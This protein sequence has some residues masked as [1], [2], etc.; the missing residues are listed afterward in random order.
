M[1]V[2]GKKR[3]KKTRK[4]RLI[5]SVT[6]A[7]HVSFSCPTPS[8]LPPTLP[9]S[10]PPSLPRA[11]SRHLPSDRSYLSCLLQRTAH[12]LK[13]PKEKRARSLDILPERN[14]RRTIC[15]CTLSCIT[16]VLFTFSARS[17]IV[18]IILVMLLFALEQLVCIFR[19]GGLRKD[20]LVLVQTGEL[21]MNSKA[22][23][24]TLYA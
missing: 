18:E 3:R 5:S 23:E 21:R 10:L 19:I 8:F 24:R 14:N 15:T 6:R 20:R 12:R 2:G 17:P 7:V 4:E 22:N 16:H 9:H 11:H 13:H 1:H